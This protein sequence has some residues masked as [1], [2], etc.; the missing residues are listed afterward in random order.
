[1]VLKGNE[2]MDLDQFSKNNAPALMLPYIRELVS[3][4]TI[5]A[6]LAPIVFPPINII[7]ILQNNKTENIESK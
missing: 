4:T 3:T 1:L 6:G 7:S 2:N 5:R